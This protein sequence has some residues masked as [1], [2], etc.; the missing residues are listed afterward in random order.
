[1]SAART[2]VL[3]VQGAGVRAGAERALLARLHDLSDQDVDATVAFL[4]RG[5][6][7]DE[8][9]ATGT[10]VVDLDPLP[11]LRHVIRTRASFA[12][13]AGL[14]RAQADVVEACGE[15]MA[16]LAGWAARRAGRPCVFN[17]Q[18][19]PLREPRAAGIQAVGATSRPA[20]TVVPSKWMRD[21]LPRALYAHTHV[22]PNALVL[23]DLPTT[24][25][26]I[27]GEL[28]WPEDAFVVGLFG[29]LVAWKGA[30]VL[31]RAA[32]RLA[33]EHP[34]ARFLV[35]GGTLFGLEPAF[36][37]RLEALIG[38]LGLGERVALTG[39]REDS[40]AL[41]LDCDVVCHCSQEPEP[42]G[43]VVVEAMALGRPTIATRSRG[44]E[45][46]IEDGRTGLLVSP[47]DDRALAQAIAGLI[48]DGARRSAIA[49]AGRQA[50]RRDFSS[51]AVA[52]RLAA[53]YHDLARTATP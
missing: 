28:G 42:F 44:P 20:L 31:V 23:D 32:A 7:R 13:L 12:Q 3:F 50:A 1:M 39:H 29:R 46:V 27:R 37:A 5:P 33:A 21:A 15:K 2:R 41:M 48:R 43:M 53:I 14:A 47:A 40:L 45:E 38:E 9:R 49:D 52:P 18:D 22:V 26:G 10:R 30:E 34:E 16:A 24:P 8:V 19:Q 35:V 11:R 6:F 25:A 36:R 4:A 51:R 17:L